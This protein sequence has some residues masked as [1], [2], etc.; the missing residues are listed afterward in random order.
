MKFN[1]LVMAILAILPLGAFAAAPSGYY[2][3]CQGLNKAE[4]LEALEETVSEHQ[5]VGYSGLWTLFGES[6]VYSDGKIWDMYS[7]KHWT[8]KTE[9]CGNYSAVGDCYNR[10]HSMPKSW[11]GDQEPMYSDAFHI[12]PTDGKVNGQRANYP[13]GECAN[14]TTLASNGGVKALGKLGASTF[15]GYSG[16]VFEPVDEYKGDFA[17]SYFYM[18]ACYNSHIDDWNSEMLAGNSYPAFTDWSVNLLMKWHRQDPVSQKELDRQEA[19]YAKQKNRNPFIDHPEMAEYIWGDKQNESWTESTTPGGEP[20][21]VLPVDGS[22]LDFGAVCGS[23]T[24]S[25]VVKGTSLAE[26]VSITSSSAQFSVSPNTISA[27]TAN[28]ADGGTVNVTWSV[29]EAGEASATLSFVSGSASVKVTVKGDGMVGLTSLPARDITETS[30]IASWTYGGGEFEDGCYEV[31]TENASTKEQTI[32]RAKANNREALI[33][34]LA[35]A[36]NYVYWVRSKNAETAKQSFATAAPQPSIQVV[37]SAQLTLSATA[38]EPSEACEVVFESENVEGN[39]NVSVSEPFQLSANKS[40][41]ATELTLDAQESRFYV[42]IFSRQAG[43]FSTALKFAVGSYVN[44]DTEVSATVANAS[45]AGFVEDFEAD[46]TGCSTYNGCDY[47]G[48]VAKWHFANVGIWSDDASRA[49]SGEQCPRFG[50]NADS[51]IEMTEDKANGAGTVTVYARRWSAKDGDCA[52]RIDYS[53][54]GGSSW[55]STTEAAVTADDY[56]KFTFAINKEGNVRIR[57]QQTKGQ[58]FTIDDVSI[59]D[60]KSQ[61][62]VEGLEGNAA[63]DAFCRGGE[64]CIE[65]SASVQARVYGVD[66]I[67]YFDGSLAAGLNRMNLPKGLYVVAV[68]GF[69]RS[70]MVK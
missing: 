26:A 69:T 67:V 68:D 62:S 66:G 29:M 63:W 8:F 2:N 44:D 22:V 59:E 33:E 14:G 23:S 13:F 53:T 21:F 38:G 58:R 20:K 60:F 9:Q 5:S 17:R 34:G 35:P 12:Y 50:K 55:D 49:H 10:E 19:I 25:L 42:R 1:K 11:F 51:S 30:Y 46:A 40:D 37:N 6:D 24:L 39:I 48:S 61:S 57:V 31:I 32:A 27:E 65:A 64:L 45:A 15:P 43:V 28:S 16:T 7:T 36:T 52:F 41:W 56:Q 3:K 47:N 70:V 54:D 18:A 4:L